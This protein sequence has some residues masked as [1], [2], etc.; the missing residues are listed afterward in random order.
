[1]FVGLECPIFT[2]LAYML[3]VL[4]NSRKVVRL[5]VNS[6]RIDLEASHYAPEFGVLLENHRIVMHFGKSTKL[7]F[8]IS[9]STDD[10]QEENNASFWNSTRSH[11]D[12]T[13]CS[14]AQE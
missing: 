8:E 5:V 4:P 6:E 7:S 11:Q 12:G 14:S 13:N 2:H 9:W 3:F 1:M 10:E